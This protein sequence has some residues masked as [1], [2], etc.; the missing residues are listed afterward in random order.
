MDLPNYPLS[1][2]NK[3]NFWKTYIEKIHL[4]E[5][6]RPIFFYFLLLFTFLFFCGKIILQYFLYSSY[7]PDSVYV[8][9]TTTNSL[10]SMLA[11]SLPYI[12][13]VFYAALFSTTAYNQGMKI[14]FR[15][16]IHLWFLI[17]IL[18]LVPFFGFFLFL[19]LYLVLLTIAALPIVVIVKL[20]S[21]IS[22]KPIRYF[23]LLLPIPFIIFASF[24]AFLPNSVNQCA[25]IDS[26]KKRD[27]CYYYYAV[28]Y[29]E[30][31]NIYTRCLNIQ[32]SQIKDACLYRN[33]TYFGSI[34]E[35]GCD[36][37]SIDLTEQKICY[38][39]LAKKT[40]N[41]LLCDKIKSKSLRQECLT[42][43]QKP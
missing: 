9:Y 21:K 34:G 43:F 28:V 27:G 15:A 36:A 33:V 14:A 16:A 20:I 2:E 19:V 25:N 30:G 18:T 8:A 37:M 17:V 1:T 6:K 23:F 4:K 35:D 26:S 11:S 39:L 29:K 32:D 7:S 22:S 31:N 3:K 41:S 12:I 38:T 13:L 24:P 40:N 5:S 42:D 10:P